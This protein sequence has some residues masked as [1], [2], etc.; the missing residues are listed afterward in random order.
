MSINAE[1]SGQ[2]AIKPIMEKKAKILPPLSG[3]IA[4]KR[5]NPNRNAVK[6]A[7]NILSDLPPENRSSLNV[8]LGD[9]MLAPYIPSG[10]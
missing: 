9:R 4:K 2:K 7:P 10:F 6:K 1:C 3:M 5:R 8:R